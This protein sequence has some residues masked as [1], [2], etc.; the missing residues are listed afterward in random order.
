MEEQTINQIE[1]PRKS[2]WWIW[3]IIILILIAVGISIYFWLSGGNTLN[4]PAGN[5]NPIPPPLP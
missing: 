1:P 2:N 5:T 3:I 4:I